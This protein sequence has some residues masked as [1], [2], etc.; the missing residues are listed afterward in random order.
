MAKEGRAEELKRAGNKIDVEKSKEISSG[1][2]QAEE[3][4]NKL[5]SRGGPIASILD[6]SARRLADGENAATVKS[7]AY[8]KVRAEVSKTLAPSEGAGARGPEGAPKAPETNKPESAID[9]FRAEQPAPAFYSK[10]A[11]VAF[12]KLPTSGSGQ[13]MLATLKNAGVKEERTQ[14]DGPGRL[15]R[16]E[17][18]SL[19]V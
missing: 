11:R 8:Q 18:Q 15:P 14:V 10:A 12:D 6:D 5:S 16:V 1:A 13:S 9:L 4:Y 7:D 17:G 3:V 19:K 2:A